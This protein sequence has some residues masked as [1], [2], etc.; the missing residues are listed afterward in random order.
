MKNLN[1]Q[2]PV[3]T[4]LQFLS[5]AQENPA[6]EETGIK[7]DINKQMPMSIQDRP[8][9]GKNGKELKRKRYNLLLYPSLY[10]EIEKIAYVKRIS[11]NEA[12]NQA[13]ELYLKV[14]KTELEKYAEIEKLKE[15]KNTGKTAGP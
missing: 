2:N 3:D 8:K 14:G 7:H 4:A 10:K 11:I 13:I 5:N 6:V 9:T 15:S 12:V 1:I